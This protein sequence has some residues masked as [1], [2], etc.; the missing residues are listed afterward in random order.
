MKKPENIVAFFLATLPAA[1]NRLGAVIGVLVFLSSGCASTEAT[2]KQLYEQL[3]QD[4]RT[5]FRGINIGDKIAKIKRLNE[6]ENPVYEDF[7]G[8]KYVYPIQN[9]KAWVNYYIDNLRTGQETN[10]VTAISLEIRQENEI[11]TAELYG[12]IRNKFI[13]KYGLPSGSY[14]D[15]VWEDSNYPMEVKLSMSLEKKVILI[16][17]TEKP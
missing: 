4:E 10:R 3:F 6:G 2:E 15:F 13:R 11:E 14:G 17:F 12:E 7:L 8:L 1:L 5:A 9:G 16:Y